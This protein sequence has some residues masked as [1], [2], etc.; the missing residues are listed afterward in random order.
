M[1]SNYPKLRERLDKI[2][3]EFNKILYKEIKY[4]GIEPVELRISEINF[5]PRS[6]ITKLTYSL[7]DTLEKY[8]KANPPTQLQKKHV[9]AAQG[10]LQLGRHQSTAI[11][12]LLDAL[13]GENEEARDLAIKVLAESSSKISDFDASYGSY[14]NQINSYDYY[15]D[16]EVKIKE[17]GNIIKLVEDRGCTCDIN[18]TN[19]GTFAS[20]TDCTRS[21][22]DGWYEKGKGDEGLWV[23]SNE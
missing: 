5:V 23:K 11:E 21:E 16:A 10:L 12:V 17:N 3:W 15:K 8:Q 6:A 4:Y 14:I 1:S 18:V 19:E 2:L 13:Q 22:Y 20:C 7:R 9:S